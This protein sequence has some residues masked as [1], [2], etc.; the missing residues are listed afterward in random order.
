MIATLIEREVEISLNWPLAAL[1]SMALLV[2]TLMLFAIY[3]RL[4]DVQR[5]LG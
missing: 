1:M 2:A 4:T 3:Q 5:M